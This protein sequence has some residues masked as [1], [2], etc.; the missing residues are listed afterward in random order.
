[1]DGFKW[2][3]MLSFEKLIAPTVLKIIYYIGLVVLAL[4]TLYQ[5]FT[6]FGEYSGGITQV[7]MALVAFPFAALG[8]RVIMELYTVMFGMYE[9][10]GE[11]RDSLKK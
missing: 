11:I 10:L 8:L 3:D 5:V 9:R 4:A 7:V 1:M 2:Q 6:A